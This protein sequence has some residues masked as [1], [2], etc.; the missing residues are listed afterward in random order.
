MKAT[1]SQN[2]STFE[3]LNNMSMLSSSINQDISQNSLNNPINANKPKE[4]NN[5]PKGGFGFIKRGDSNPKS[6]SLEEN[7][8]PSHFIPPKISPKKE[9]K[10]KKK[11]ENILN[12]YRN[13]MIDYHQKM[14]NYNEDF[15]N[16][17]R[18]LTEIRKELNNLEQNVKNEKEKVNDLVKNQNTQIENN[19]F[20][21][22]EKI[23]EEIKIA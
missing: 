16:F 10:P 23:E 8:Q 3:A 13:K 1:S 6:S 4:N 7:P 9:E 5:K 22:A 14:F 19:N 2:T 15:K 21:M 18:K 11:L 12:L 20:D 17:I